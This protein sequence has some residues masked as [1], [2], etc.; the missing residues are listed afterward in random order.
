VF[1]EHKLRE[2]IEKI[3]LNPNSVTLRFNEPMKEHCT[4]RIGGP[5]E[6]FARPL[7]VAALRALL[8]WARAEKVPVFVLGCGANILVADAGIR[9]LVLDMGGLDACRILEDGLTMEAQ[10]G[11]DVSVAAELALSKGLGGLDFIYK[12]PGSIGGA[13]FMN[14]RCYGSEIAD[15]LES[16]NYLDESGVECTMVPERASFRYK[17]TPFQKHPWVISSARFRLS[18][19]DP[20]ALRVR[21]DELAADRTAKGHFQAPCAGSVFKNNHAFGQPTGKIIDGLGLR[22]LRIGDAMVSDFHANIFIN[23]GQAT[24]RDMRALIGAVHDRVLAATGFDLEP[25]VVMA[26]DWDG[27]RS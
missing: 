5:A 25:E 22:G 3:N 4:F 14:A 2:S 18:P 12:M 26:G 15:I 11:L 24:A 20:A 1:P 9:G 17:D 7:S 23:A 13:V 10:A 16:V 21:M 6:L 19:G 8:A 27:T